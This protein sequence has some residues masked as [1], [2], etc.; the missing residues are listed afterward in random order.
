M[1]SRGEVTGD[2][3]E[4]GVVIEVDAGG[5][6]LDLNFHP[7]NGSPLKQAE[8]FAQSNSL[9]VAVAQPLARRIHSL[10][11]RSHDPNFSQH[12]EAAGAP[13][14]DGERLA[15]KSGQ[16]QKGSSKRAAREDDYTLKSSHSPTFVQ[17]S[18]EL[19]DLA[20]D[21][22]RAESLVPKRAIE[23][24]AHDGKGYMVSSSHGVSDDTHAHN[25]RATARDSQGS[26]SRLHTQQKGFTQQPNDTEDRTV[27]SSH[28]VAHRG[29]YDQAGDDKRQLDNVFHRLYTQSLSKAQKGQEESKTAL[30]EQLHTQWRERFRNVS[31]VQGC[32]MSNSILPT[33]VQPMI[34]LF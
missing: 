15:S 14:G 1:G 34:T 11:N 3:V 2:P 22:D 9:P 13:V 33:T 24:Q 31:E 17:G 6:S 32:V 19:T 27:H 20:G 18:L 23:Q 29:N 8:A 5:E 21:D 12:P 30:D 10:M 16:P 28:N 25:D 4:Q 26:Q 7:E